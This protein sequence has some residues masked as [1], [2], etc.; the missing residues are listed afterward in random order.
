MSPQWDAGDFVRAFDAPSIPI[1]EIVKARLQ[2]EGI[3]VMT[4]GEAEGPYRV[5]PM[6]LWVPARFL[7]QARMLIE[8]GGSGRLEVDDS[9]TE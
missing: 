4:K 3:P 8:D 1:G 7:E 6:Q 2:A 9:P 5:G